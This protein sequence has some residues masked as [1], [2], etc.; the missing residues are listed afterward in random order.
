[1]LSR[2]ALLMMLVLILAMLAGDIW[3]VTH[4]VG[5]SMA[6][7]G[8]PVVVMGIIVAFVELG[9]DVLA[10][11]DAGAAWRKW[12]SVFGISIAVLLTVGQLLP[13]FL[14]LG[15]SLPSAN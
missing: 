14:S 8:P 6:L 13:V 2:K 15:S 7:F 12:G 4:G 11:S 5:W 10:S 9:R 3:Q 1:M